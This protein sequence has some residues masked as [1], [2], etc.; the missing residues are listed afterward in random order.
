MKSGT[1]EWTVI[2]RLFPHHQNIQDANYF[3]KAKKGEN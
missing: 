1:K 3:K 2:W